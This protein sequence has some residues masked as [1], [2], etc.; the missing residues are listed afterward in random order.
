MVSL[1]F[2]LVFTMLHTA[3]VL[4][5]YSNQCILKERISDRVVFLLGSY[6]QYIRKERISDRVVFLLGSYDQCILKEWI[7]DR[8]VFL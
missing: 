7:S 5:V 3:F 6:D 2:H 1:S 4:Q 8:V